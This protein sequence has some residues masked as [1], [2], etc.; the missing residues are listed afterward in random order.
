MEAN[1]DNARA[2]KGTLDT[3]CVS[4]RQM[5]SVEKCNILFST[6]TSVDN[7]VEVREIIDIWT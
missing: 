3:Y 1:G 4:F 2:L 6:N 7:K 5:L